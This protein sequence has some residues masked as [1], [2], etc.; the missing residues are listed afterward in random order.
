MN[1]NIP[2]KTIKRI[3]KKYYNG[4]I[5]TNTCNYVRDLV[6]NF[7]EDVSKECVKEFDD[8]NMR[9]REHNL[10]VL[11]RL[12]TS[13]FVDLNNKIYKHI[14]NKI[15]GE[16]GQDNKLLLCQD[17]DIIRKNRDDVIIKDAGVEVV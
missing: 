3:M 10:P 12:D 5:T 9:R 17:S 7:A 11:K 16:V 6:L 15:F 8:Y 13:V 2:L 4:G 14:F 1:N